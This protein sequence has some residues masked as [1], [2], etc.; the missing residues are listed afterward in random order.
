MDL[1]SEPSNHLGSTAFSL[2]RPGAEGYD[3]DQVDAF[4]SKVVEALRHEPPTMAPWEVHD[5]VFAISRVHR[6]YDEHEVDDF[7][8]RA[9]AA[10]RVAHGEQ[11]DVPA[12]GDAEPL[13]T[14]WWPAL[15]AC[16]IAVAALLAALVLAR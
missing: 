4:V 14:R 15:T 2:A 9:E 13:A 12:T 6:G 1:S 7:L 11:L 8:D 5:Q 16:L 3:P 10:L